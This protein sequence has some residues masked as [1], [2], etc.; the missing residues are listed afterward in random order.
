MNIEFLF[1]GQRFVWDAEK[2]FNNSI[3]HG[4]R[5]ETACQVFFDRFVHVQD[6][7][8][9]EEQRDAAVGVTEDLMLLLVVHRY[10]DYETIRV[11]SARP[12]TRK[13][14]MTYENSE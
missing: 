1:R 12:A 6:A 4:V 14:R 5:F 7:S 8:V 13:E 10:R 2:A 11:I 3:K 9:G